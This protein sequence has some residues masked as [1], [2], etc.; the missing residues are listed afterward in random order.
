MSH[1]QR[2]CLLCLLSLVGLVSGAAHA[3]N[4]YLDELQRRAAE[5]ELADTADWH[6][7]IHYEDN[8]LRPGVTS[9]VASPWFF[10]AENGHSDPAAEL[11]ATLAAFFETDDLGPRKEP[12][13]CVFQAR[14]A[15][16]DRH[17]DFDGQ[18]MPVTECEQYDNWTAGLDPAAVSLIFPA[19]Y[20]NS[21]S[22]MFGHTLLRIDSEGQEQRTELLAYAINFAANTEEDNGVI[23]AVKGLTGGYPG[24]YGV[25]PYYEK[26]KQYAWIENRD[27]WA[28]PMDLSAAELDRLVAHLWEMRG[29]AF[30]YYFLTKNCSYQLLA[31]LEAA[32]PELRLTDAF[33]WYA[34]PADTIRAVGRVPD[35][36]GPPDYRPSLATVLD[37][38]AESLPESQLDLAL[39]V[40]D[41]REPPDGDALANLPPRAR[42]RVLEVAHD[43]LYYRYQTGAVPRQS[44]VARAR[45]I[46]LAR[47]RVA[48]DA[49]FPPVAEPATPPEAGHDTLRVAAGPVWEGDD[50][51]IGL[52]LR[53]AYHD[54]LDPP[55]GYTAGAQINFMD[56]ALRADVDDDELELDRLTLIDIVSISARSD[57]FKPISWQIGT[58]FRQRP[59]AA[60]MDEDAHLGYYVEGGPGLAWG[61]L[62]GVTA[63]AFGLGSADVN[64]GFEHGYALGAGASLGVLAY[65]TPGWQLRAEV[66]G[67]DYAAGDG[68]HRA[69]AKL[70]QQWPLPGPLAL[71]AEIG[72]EENSRRDYG[73][74]M[75]LLQGYF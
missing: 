64:H 17:L 31:L 56:V 3:D 50:A 29:V 57:L 67:L 11:D 10:Q 75:L 45:Q 20:P 34:I 51:G 19:A 13:R 36:L 70:T 2:S 16:L 37:R 49:D 25:F 24:V 22:S 62:D 9:T 27:V 28:Y 40:A 42:A 1:R 74:G 43:H 18:R 39:A 65:P 5:Q 48:T 66:G 26:V 63:Y 38:H 72:Y 4:A 14:Y 23:F 59:V 54:L 69:W 12:P 68:G 73:R 32:R 6:A 61:D 44:G 15:F 33:D 47:S 53:P 7:L 35:L 8:W 71:R 55:G 58:G 21:P 52:R 30:D 46:L 41:G 60:P